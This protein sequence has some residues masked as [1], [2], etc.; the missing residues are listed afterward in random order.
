MSAAAG[1]KAEFVY[2]PS[3]RGGR[4]DLEH[5]FHELE[6]GHQARAGAGDA[7]RQTT[8]GPHV[9]VEAFAEQG[10]QLRHLFRLPTTRVP[11]GSRM[12]TIAPFCFAPFWIGRTE[13]SQSQSLWLQHGERRR[14][15]RSL[16]CAAI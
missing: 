4:T 11:G 2:Q 6:G 7:E 14:P 12:N 16:Q 8:P 5:G 13:P 1:K 9:R 10:Q 3:Q 15:G